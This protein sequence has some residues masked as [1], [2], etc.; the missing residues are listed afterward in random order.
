MNFTLYLQSA[1]AMVPEPLKT[2]WNEGTNASLLGALPTV[3]T[4]PLFMVFGLSDMIQACVKWSLYVMILGMAF[5]VGWLLLLVAVVL[6]VLMVSLIVLE[7][8]KYI[9]GLEAECTAAQVMSSLE[10]SECD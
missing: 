4:A 8:I 5:V 10:M 9:I 7:A 3:V 6:A 1:L 2:L